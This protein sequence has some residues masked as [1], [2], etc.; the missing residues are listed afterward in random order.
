[1]PEAP[2]PVVLPG[3][4]ACFSPAEAVHPDLQREAA[5]RLGPLTVFRGA[6]DCGVA[7]YGNPQEDGGAIVF[8]GYLSDRDELIRELQLPVDT[9]DAR[10]AAAAYQRW[11]RDV[12]D[13]LDG[14]YLLA[15][16]DGRN[17]RLMIGHDALGRHPVFYARE[18]GSLWFSPNVLALASSGGVPRR[19]NRL[20][21][22][23]LILFHWP[24]A[25]QTFFERIWR[26]RPG[27][28]LEVNGS[29]EASEHEYWHPFPADHED[30]LPDEGVVEEFEAAL[31]TALRRCMQLGA[32]GIMLSGGLDSITVAALAAD[33][34]R[35]HGRPPLVAVSGRS[36]RAPSAE[37]SR[38]PIVTAALGMP[39]VV[40]TTAEWL[41][42]RDG[43]ELSLEI[44][45]SLPSPSRI[46]WVGTYAAFYRRTA[47]QGLRVLLTGAGGD[48]WL[49]VADP[50][51]ADLLRRLR[52][53]ELARL[54]RADV[55]T[56]GG[57]L[58]GAARRLLW[59]SG[60][61]PHVDSLA[62]W[63]LPEQKLRY[64]RRR[65]H[66]HLPA[67]VCPDRQLR[68]E[69]VER[70]LGRRTPPLTSEGRLPP[71]YYRH[72]LRTLTNPYMHYENETAYHVETWCGLRLLSPYHDRRFVSF[73]N[74]ISPRALV[75]G[76]RYKGLL[77]PIVARRLPHLSLD[78]QRKEYSEQ[79]R[80][81]QLTELRESI[82]RA[83]TPSQLREL[84]ALD[85][86]DLRA[87]AGASLQN[88]ADQRYEPH[89]QKFILMSAERWLR[90]HG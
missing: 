60:L 68:E 8:D 23:L 78:R 27:C 76:A 46:Y 50:H 74:R 58:R 35:A 73:A 55:S 20:S 44:A 71:S 43:I 57:S 80:A 62:A 61:R 12:F 40:S 54:I 34:T 53:F 90:A 17:H 81:W 24:E 33:Y 70:L 4:Y 63:M 77:R 21:L 79:D 3:W 72:T 30:W 45:P 36:G 64:H 39:H 38:Q 83:W 1:M 59:T 9:S 31:T 5:V 66:E 22:A 75:H 25:G 82:S 14:R 42:G 10:L 69:V 15:V 2:P 26:L 37:E 7:S 51:A 19:P 41:Q 18:N 87:L 32:Q 88:G 85:I 84:S 28:Y 56:G 67:W 47:A 65:W 6:E 86:V 16:W 89:I 48:N 49:G 52:L 11:G 29:L 13:R